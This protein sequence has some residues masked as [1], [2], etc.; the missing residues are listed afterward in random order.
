MRKGSDS[1]QKPDAA[2]SAL[3]L[4]VAMIAARILGF[5]RDGVLY[6][7]F[8]LVRYTDA[9]QAAFTLPDTIY[10]LLVGGA[11]S[12][13]FI[14]VFSHYLAKDE[15]EDAWK[16]ASLTFQAVSWAMLLLIAGAFAFAPQL[17]AVFFPR[18][19]AATL[20]LTVALTRIMLFQVIFMALGGICAGILQS[21]HIFAPSAWSGVVYN[22]LI[23]AFGIA[24]AGPIESRFPG[25]GIAAFAFGV[26]A[27]AVANFLIQGLSLRRVGIAYRF[28][29]D[30]RHPGFRKMAGLMLPVLLGLSAN[31]INLIVNMSLASGLGEG[32]LSAL[33]LAQRFMQLPVSIFAISIAMTLFPILNEEA[34]QERLAD[35]CRDYAKGFKAILFICIPCSLFLAVLAV[36]MIRLLFQNGLFGAED[37]AATA[38]AL[39]FYAVGIF[40]QGGIHLTSRAFYALQDTATPVKMAVVGAAVNIGGSILLLRLL[41]QGGIAFA[42]SLAGIVNL[43][44]LLF[45]LRRRA[46]H[47]HGA[48]ILRTAVKTLAASVPAAAAAWLFVYGWSI[49]IGS[50]GKLAQGAELLAAGWIAC[51]VFFLLARRFRMPEVDWF[52]NRM[53]KRFMPGL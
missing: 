18:F 42:Y 14:P 44:L 27:G 31:E 48:E 49:L 52:L 11:F 47:I 26:V 45:V 33:K 25:F 22:L 37:V 43:V 8:G 34:A 39:Y 38:F 32:L 53:K 13:A 30:F 9:Y 23:I 12:A 6:A 36:P 17:L 41:S 24:F 3:V 28:S 1:I 40:A 5:V 46:G 19:D 4:M 29:L 15:R 20:A 16:V 35:F 7:R 2:Q 51:A 21:H 50:A 10:M